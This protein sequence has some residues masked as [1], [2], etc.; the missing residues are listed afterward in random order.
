MNFGQM[1]LSFVE[2]YL[3]F[4]DQ[5]IGYLLSR[6]LFISYISFAQK[7][8]E[9]CG[10]NPKAADVPIRVSKQVTVLFGLYETRRRGRHTLSV[11]GLKRFV[12]CD[13][14]SLKH[15]QT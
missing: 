6:D 13:A 3:S 14:F 12:I 7:L 4:P 1:L 9:S 8:F 5:H 2:L 15:Y 10:I 11:R